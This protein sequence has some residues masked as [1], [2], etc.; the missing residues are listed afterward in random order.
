[1]KHIALQ[2][3][4]TLA[5]AGFLLAAPQ[6][7]TAPTD[8]KAVKMDTKKAPAVPA[9]SAADIA[10]AQAKGLVWVN[11][12]TGVYHKDGSFYGKTKKGK[13][14]TEDEAKKAGHHSAKESA[15]GKKPTPSPTNA[16]EAA[17][18]K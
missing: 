13:F 15:I 8:S 17:P 3:A 11:L 10:A 9:A 12:N 16:K 18:K 2:L 7:K 6:A 14:M 1:M 5:T 4:L